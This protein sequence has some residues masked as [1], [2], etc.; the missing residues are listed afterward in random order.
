MSRTL[1]FLA[2]LLCAALA[3][4]QFGPGNRA[5]AAPSTGDLS[6]EQLQALAT[7]VAP[8]DVVMYTTPHCPHCAQ[9][10]GWLRQYGFGFTE[11][12][13]SRERRCEQEFTEHGGTGTPYLVVR[14]HHMKDGFDSDEFLMA[15]HR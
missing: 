2:V 9:A 15:L 4:K 3:W 11:C 6:I 12:D 13:M 1:A 8:A 7:T 14:G 5:V 10:K